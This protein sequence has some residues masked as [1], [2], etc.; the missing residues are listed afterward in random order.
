MLEWNFSL[1]T[2]PVLYSCLIWELLQISKCII[3]KKKKLVQLLITLTD[4]GYENLSIN[5][6]QAMEFVLAAWKLVLSYKINNC[7]HKAGALL[8]ETDDDGSNGEVV[9]GNELLYWRVQISILLYILLIVWLCVGNY[10]MRR[11]LLVC[12]NNAVMIKKVD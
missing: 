7:F 2:V 3:E 4:A 5:L 9:S 6:V 12:A 1:Q 10:R 8:E 11:L